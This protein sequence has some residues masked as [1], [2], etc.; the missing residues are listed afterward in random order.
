MDQF[1]NLFIQFYYDFTVIGSE[2]WSFTIYVESDQQ[3][4]NP[5]YEGNSVQFS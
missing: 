3:D 2:P 1:L 5:K 4:D